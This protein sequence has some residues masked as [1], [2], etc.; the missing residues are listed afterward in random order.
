MQWETIVPSK[1][2][3]LL[4][5]GPLWDVRLQQL[6]WVDIIGKA[7]HRYDPATG[8]DTRFEVPFM[9]GCLALREGG[10][11]LVAG[12]GGFYLW[13]ESG[14][15]QPL[16][17]PEGGRY[18]MNDGKAD[19]EGRF[20]AG[21]VGGDMG[22]GEGGLYLLDTR[23]HV[24]PR[25]KGVHISNGLDWSP[26]LKTM[27]F[28]DSTTRAVMAYDFELETG[29]MSNPRVITRIPTPAVP[30]GMTVDAEGMLWVAQWMGGCV[31]RFH[32]D[33]GEEIGR[34]ELPARRVSCPVFGGPQL[35]DLYVTTARLNLPGDEPQD[36]FPDDQGGAVFVIRG[37]GQ[38]KAGFYFKG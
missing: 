29:G 28:I 34:I 20:F 18:R 22:A 9:P 8:V 37:A 38:G 17:D 1:A 30:D 7:I 35:R 21:S 12:S 5:E 27:Y 25:L 23:Y 31:S 13:D 33:T 36:E 4:A 26:D 32:P 16:A 3:A 6:W 24:H 2:G 19:P 11:L 10:G 14:E 15:L